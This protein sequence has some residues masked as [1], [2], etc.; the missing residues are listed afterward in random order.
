MKQIPDTAVL[1]RRK[2]D[3]GED[4]AS[5]F[6]LNMLCMH[7]NVSYWLQGLQMKQF[8]PQKVYVEANIV[9]TSVKLP[10]LRRFILFSSPQYSA[11]VS[12]IL[13]ISRQGSHRLG[14]IKFPDF[15][16]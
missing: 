4:E 13:D 11:S 7:R 5:K 15:S 12:K 10:R 9:F 3:N 6:T 16:R 1:F 2:N 14:K 8:H